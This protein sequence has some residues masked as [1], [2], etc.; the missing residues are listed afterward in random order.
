MSPILTAEMKRIVDEQ[1]LGF[2]ATVDPDGSP[3]LSPKATFSV[4]DDHTIGYC[5]IRSPRTMSNIARGS[6]IEVNFVDPF[7]RKGCRFKGRA[8]VITRGSGGFD[9]VVKHF[10][11]HAGIADRARSIVV[12]RVDRALPLISPAYDGGQ[13]EESDIRRLWTK[14]FREIQPGS[15]FVE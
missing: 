2:V 15:R 5:E 1:R 12:I 13:A 3:N 11:K 9:D 14:R 4:I 7:T 8:E 6:A 10:S